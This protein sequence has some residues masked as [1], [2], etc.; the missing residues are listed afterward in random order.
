[1]PLVP[2][3]C[4]QCGATL[5]IDSAQDAAIC[6]F[7]NTPFVVEKAINNY[8]VTNTTNIGAVE[9]L[10]VEGARSV[11]SQL[12][13]AETLM[14]LRDYVKAFKS[15]KALADDHAYEWRSWWG[16]ARAKTCDYTN[17]VGLRE[18]EKGD[19]EEWANRAMQL[20]PAV[21]KPRLEK[22]F[23]GYKDAYNKAKHAERVE[24][25]G[26][27]ANL[28][29]IEGMSQAELLERYKE[30]YE[31][32]WKL[33]CQ[34][35]E[36]RDRRWRSMVCGVICMVL[37]A[38]SVWFGNGN[39]AEPSLFVIVM[40]VAVVLCVLWFVAAQFMLSSFRNRHAHSKDEFSL[41]EQ[42]AAIMEKLGWYT[43][44][45]DP[46]FDPYSFGEELRRCRVH[47]VI[48]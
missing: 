47:G 40:G 39:L 32:T 25:A 29:R 48:D 31:A 30:L 42:D 6:S 23:N 35:K 19:V 33:K 20:A 46:Y 10:H 14:E 36:W 45:Q 4:T 2:A 44:W 17:V 5:S 12:R 16:M 27:E 43:Y 8:N 38:A 28:S 11:E 1:M 24:I 34:V 9:H 26:G 13:S 3:K 7:C 15:F 18:Y 41:A 37:F 21:E 22:T